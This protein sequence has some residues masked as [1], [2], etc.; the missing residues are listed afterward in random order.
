MCILVFSSDFV[1]TNLVIRVR[2]CIEYIRTIHRV[3]TTNQPIQIFV[4]RL[5][6]QYNCKDSIIRNYIRSIFSACLILMSMQIAVKFYQNRPFIYTD[7]LTN[8]QIHNIIRI[9]I[10]R[11]LYFESIL[12]SPYVNV[13]VHLWT[14]LVMYIKM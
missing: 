1:S 13:F 2:E 7:T 4:R 9:D 11:L 8:F 10:R 6:I 14:S 3:P 12:V 5:H